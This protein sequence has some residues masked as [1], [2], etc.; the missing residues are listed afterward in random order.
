[1]IKHIST[2]GEIRIDKWIA[3]FFLI[4]IVVSFIFGIFS[5]LIN[6]FSEIEDYSKRGLGIDK[7]RYLIYFTQLED[8]NFTKTNFVSGVSGKYN[9]PSGESYTYKYKVAT[10]ENRSKKEEKILIEYTFE[11]QNPKINEKSFIQKNPALD[12]REI[13]DIMISNNLSPNTPAFQYKNVE[14][15]ISY[16]NAP[17][18]VFVV[19]LIPYVYFCSKILSDEK[20]WEKTLETAQRIRNEE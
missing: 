17:W 2:P 15:I 6:P 14:D 7:D 9:R 5:L 20:M 12:D 16:N 13:K 11:F 10:F 3:N 1:M 19:A 8:I 18:R 4:V